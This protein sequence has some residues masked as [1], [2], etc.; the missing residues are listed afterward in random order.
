MSFVLALFGSV[1]V[2]KNTRDLQN[3]KPRYPDA[4]SAPSVQGVTAREAGAVQAP[5]LRRRSR[6]P[7]IRRCAPDSPPIRFI[8]AGAHDDGDIPDARLHRN[9]AAHRGRP[10][11]WRRG[12]RS[13]W[14]RTTCA[15]AQPVQAVDSL[16]S[17]RRCRSRPCHPRH[18]RMDHHARR[19]AGRCARRSPR[20]RAARSTSSRSARALATTMRRTTG[21]TASTRPVATSS[22]RRCRLQAGR[23]LARAPACTVRTR[24]RRCARRGGGRT[25]YAPNVLGIALTSIDFMYFPAA[26]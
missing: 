18:S 26:A 25:S 9:H 17:S 16:A 23:R 12:P 15:A 6:V 4:E 10:M 8:H 19:P 22:R 21:S 3:A 13:C 5:V 20:W 1:A 14:R 11:P 24:S 7:R 2:Q